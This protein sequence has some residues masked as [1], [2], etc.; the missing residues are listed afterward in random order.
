VWTLAKQTESGIIN[1]H[2]HQFSDHHVGF[3]GI[4]DT[5]DLDSFPR[6]VE[7]LGPGPHISMVFGKNSLDARYY[8]AE[9]KVIRPV[10]I[11]KIIGDRRQ[12]IIPCSQKRHTG[13]DQDF[14]EK[15]EVYD[16]QIRVFGQAGQRKLKKCKVAC[17]GCG[18]IGSLICIALARLGVGTIILIDPDVVEPSNLNRLAGSTQADAIRKNAKV[19]MLRRYLHRINPACQVVPLQASIIN[20]PEILN[21]LK[22]LDG[23]FGGTDNQSS[24]HELNLFCSKYLIPYFDTGTGIQADKDLKIAHAGGQVRIAIP[25]KGCLHCINGIDKNVAQQEMLPEPDR[26]IAIQRGYIAGADEKAPAVLSLNGVI[27]HLAV[28]EFMAY[29]TGFRPLKR[30][31]FHDFMDATV[32]SGNFP[33]NPQCYTCSP[34]GLLGAGDNGKTMPADVPMEIFDSPSRPSN[35]PNTQSEEILS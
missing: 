7:C 30:Y 11:V 33:P 6:T 27:A 26:Q 1:F 18:G 21:F 19:M 10:H 35:H 25:G 34:F 4:D 23:V 12:E 32:R 14:S 28:T 3:S 17:V 29:I 22:S 24:R 8:D 5:C 13:Q 9:K 31:I 2:S 20:N 15:Q 16:R